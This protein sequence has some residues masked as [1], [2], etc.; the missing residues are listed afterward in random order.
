M[1]PFFPA[2]YPDELFYSLCARF[3][4]RSSNLITSWSM[5]DL[6]GNKGITIAFHLPRYLNSLKE[7]LMSGSLIEPDFLIENTTLLPFYR[8]FL[9]KERLDKVKNLMKDKGTKNGRVS[10][11]AGIISSGIPMLNHLRYCMFCVKEDEEKFEEPYWHRSHQVVGINVCHKHNVLLVESEVNNGLKNRLVTLSD[12][13]ENLN[14]IQII[15]N[16]DNNLYA[17]SKEINYLL[18]HHFESVGSSRLKT[19]YMYYLKQLSIVRKSG[20]VRHKEF[21]QQF[22]Q[23]YG[24]ILLKQLNIKKPD[25]NR[26]Y[27]LSYLLGKHSRAIHPLYH[28]LLINF[29]GITLQEFLNNDEINSEQ[30]RN[31]SLFCLNPVAHHFQELVKENMDI[32]TK[33]IEDNLSVTNHTLNLKNL[34]QKSHV[35]WVL[36]DEELSKRVVLLLTEILNKEGKPQRITKSLINRKIGRQWI[37]KKHLDKLPLTKEIIDSLVEPTEDYHIRRI[38]WAAHTL[39]EEGVPLSKNKIIKK[40]GLLHKDAEKITDSIDIELDKYIK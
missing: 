29:L 11:T 36:R 39:Y 21:L 20:V 19:K 6:F 25:A 5:E 40:A 3:H 12:V 7:N 34:R 23:Y 22:E 32:Q 10:L 8:P 31:D 2:P 18:N 24:N 17:L 4:E 16:E 14:D 15:K 38:K 26:N 37:I 33:Q 30:I 35:D 28:I 1:L 27:W 9:P 13:L